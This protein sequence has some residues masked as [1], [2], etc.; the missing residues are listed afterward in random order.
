MLPCTT[1]THQSNTS[2]HWHHKSRYPAKPH[3][4]SNR[5]VYAAQT[6]LARQ[7]SALLFIGSG[8][9]WKF[10]FF[11]KNYKFNRSMSVKESWGE[12]I[13]SPVRPTEISEVRIG[14]T[15]QPSVFSLKP[16]QTPHFNAKTKR[17]ERIFLS[18][19]SYMTKIIHFPPKSKFALWIINKSRRHLS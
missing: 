5:R 15:V 14:K 1:E 18:P 19:L 12:E 4:N 10:W 11:T 9:T 6:C 7:A 8:A 3:G 2:P 13:S 17:E 16:S